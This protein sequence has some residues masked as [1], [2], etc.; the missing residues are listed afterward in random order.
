MRA[1]LLLMAMVAM[2]AAA[3]AM[4]L[5][6]AL[7]P[8]QAVRQSL[9]S[10]PSVSAAR[11]MI[12]AE[13]ANNRRLLAGPHEW[14]VR[15]MAQRRT[16]SIGQ[17]TL[18]KHIALERPLRAPGKAGR[19]AALGEAGIA[20]AQARMA[21][22]WH[23]AAR[24]LL[25]S[26]F[27]WMRE[28]RTAQRLQEHAQV[29]QQQLGIVQRRVKAGDAPRLE[30]MLAET[31]SQRAVV[32]QAQAAAR[33]ARAEADLRKR[34]PGVVPLLPASLSAA[35][36]VAPIIPGSVRDWQAGILEHNHEI[37]L[38]Q[39]EATYSKLT[40]QR[41]ALDRHGDPTVGLHYGQERD[42]Q[43]RMVGVTVSMPFAGASRSASADAAMA[44]AQA[45][46][47]KARE[48][49]INVEN[50]AA[51]VAMQ[52]QSAS[53]LLAQFGEIA[54]QAQANAALVSKAYGLGEATLND[55]LLARRQSLEAQSA[56]EQAQVDALEAHARLLLDMHKIWS[57]R[58]HHAEGG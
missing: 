45:A 31:E 50:D 41:V 44:R 6:G 22:T 1:T 56:A 43:E 24:G 19:D 38:A 40:A 4:D 3:Q 52:A 10:L 30:Q 25:K 21:D 33:A 58:E 46:A 36:P 9:S 18:D 29:L 16:D 5:S 8:E 34:Y 39:L 49:S 57:L 37:E 17:R 26:W 54:R 42:S 51:Q 35:Q 12:E 55:T 32:A 15:A 20:L 27:G 47:E 14:T 53:A 7:P 28:A 2:P 23:E 11:A 13:Q 48:V